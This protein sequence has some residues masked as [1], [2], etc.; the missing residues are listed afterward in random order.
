VPL[1]APPSLVFVLLSITMLDSEEVG[2]S[3][4]FRTVYMR[5]AGSFM[6]GCVSY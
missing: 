5:I 1:P 4:A 6:C 3:A 2:T